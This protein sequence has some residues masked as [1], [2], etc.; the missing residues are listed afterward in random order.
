MTAQSR[1]TL[2]TYFNDGDQPSEANFADLID[3]VV[4]I[5]DDDPPTFTNGVIAPAWKP[6]TNSTTA[7]QMQKADG[8]AILN[9]DTTNARVGLGTNALAGDDSGLA[10]ARAATNPLSSAGSHAVRD[11]STYLSATSGGYASF[12]AQAT[13]GGTFT[14]HGH[15]YNFQARNV[16]TPTGAGSLSAYTGFIS[17]PNINGPVT[18]LY[19]F[20]ALDP[21]GT[22]E[23][24]FQAVLYCGETLE[25]ATANYFLYSGGTTPSYHEGFF[26]TGAGITAAGAIKGNNFYTDND[27]NTVAFGVGVPAAGVSY[28]GTFIGHN[29]G[30]SVTSSN[31]Q[32]YVGSGAGYTSNAEGGVYIGRAA[33]YYETAANKL[34][35]DNAT[36]ASEADGRAKALIYGVFDA[37]VANQEITFNVGKHGFFGQAAVAKPTG[38]AVTAEGI[39]AALVTLG[40]IAA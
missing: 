31:N 35:I 26:Q 16:Y 37:A 22:G 1:T 15:L 17:V 40:L 10:I 32:T 13:M 38:V 33:G 19:G 28:I 30:H 12:D 39:H 20:R 11:E 4:N 25:R 5:S 8:T 27:S 3:S 18:D 29:A 2:K 9:V 6:A 21:V 36:R 34:F 24:G 14:P 23:I 7:L